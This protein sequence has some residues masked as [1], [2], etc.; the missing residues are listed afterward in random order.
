LLLFTLGLAWL[1]ASL[2]VFVRDTSQILGV[3]LTFWFW[4]TPIFFSADR[5][6]Q[7]LKFMVRWNPLAYV[8]T[9]Y[10]DC[11]LRVQ[12]PDLRGLAFLALVSLAVFIAGGIFFRQTKREFVDVL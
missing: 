1:V 3:I 5:I 12:L 2:N 8:V 9:G 11:L 10:R 7:S 4:F 6:P